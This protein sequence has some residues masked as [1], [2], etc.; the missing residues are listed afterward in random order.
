MAP[1][2]AAETAA[3]TAL[4]TLT[5]LGRYV[6][7]SHDASATFER[8]PVARCESASRPHR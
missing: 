4:P 5:V 7:Y 3:T 6:R 2:R 1:K 8:S